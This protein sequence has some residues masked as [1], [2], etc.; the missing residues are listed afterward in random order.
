[1]K[2]AIISVVTVCTV[3]VFHGSFSQPSKYE[4]KTVRKISFAGLI[5][6]NKEDL[7][8]IMTTTVGYPLKSIEVQRDIKEIFKK[9]NF[10]SVVVDIQEYEDGVELR[11]TC[12]E[13]PQIKEVIF[14]GSD[15]VMESDLASVVLM[16]EGDPL[17]KDY[18]E[19]SVEL[20]KEKYDSEGLF[21]AVITY[22]VKEVDNKENTV[23]VIFVIDEG[24]EIKVHKISVLGAINVYS[25][26]LTSL[27]DT[28]EDGLFADGD[29]KEDVYEEDKGKI[30]AYYRE[31]G[32][33]DV[34]IVQDTVENQW[35]NPEK[36]EERGIF[37]TIKISEGEKYYFEGYS[38]TIHGEK[39][40]TVFKAKD[41]FEEFE[42]KKKGEIFND[43]KFMK[44][45]QMISFK[46]ST[47]G[48]IF[49]RVIPERTVIEREIDV[50]GAK[51]KRKFVK[52]DFTIDEGTQAYIDT[53]IIKGNS[54]TK[55]KVIRREVLLKEGDLFDSRKVQLTREKVYNLGFFKEVNID[56]RPGSREGYMNLIIDVEEQPTGTISLGGGYG[57]TSGFSIFADVG[58]KNLLGNGQQVGVKFE[59]GPLKTSV[60]LSFYERWLFGWP[61]GFSASIFYSLY[62][63]ETGD[64]F[65]GSSNATYEKQSIG[66]SLG[67]AYRFLYYFAAGVTWSHTFKN[68]LNPSGDCPDS[69]WKSSKLGFQEKRTLSYYI[70]RD[71][72]DNYLNPTTGGRIGLT[73][74]ITGGRMLGGDDHFL[75]WSPEFAW[76]LSH[77]KV[78]IPFLKDHKLVI[79][80]RASGTFITRPLGE[81]HQNPV[82][83]PWLES[84]DRLFLGG[85]ETLRGWEYYDNDFPDSW[86]YIGL[87]HQMLFGVELRIPLHPQ[88][89]WM[90]VFFDAGSLWSDRYW[91]NKLIEE[92]KDTVDE[93]LA[94]GKLH[95]LDYIGKMS[96]EEFFRYFKYSYG[97]GFR[98]QIPMLPLRFWFGRKFVFEGS[99]VKHLNDLTFQFGIGDMRF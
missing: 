68:Y 14:K 82:N 1:M 66:Y 25:K 16:K 5:N 73:L 44:D 52:I 63:F 29:F 56:V 75:Q 95:R 69:I 7:N 20:L 45:R 49:A 70:Y 79:E 35:I 83:N 58:E 61:V 81:V 94:D 55:D 40:E 19:K 33:L 3:L 78:H 34:Q 76:Y 84:E 93:D 10:K 9:G 87:N 77:P 42:L 54:K 65:N 23:D 97:F 22:E 86:R 89:L 41:F 26:V 13:R 46:Y 57:T 85:P 30:L 91:E 67:L 4:N 38:M 2:K 37:I 39:E 62:T 36:K 99:K 8:E 24:E 11:F 47:K 50:D 17:R 6:I 15:E 90:A 51:Q 43:T 18:L 74:G 21:N 71:S 48:Y 53:I 88:M 92:L 31:K 72:K 60:T 64:L 27:M 32:Y 12:E 96:F 59:Y 80:I 98:I 28:K